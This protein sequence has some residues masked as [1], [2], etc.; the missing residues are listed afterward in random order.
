ME[1]MVRC[2]IRTQTMH[3]NT[4]SVCVWDR[5]SL[6]LGKCLRDV[7]IIVLH[8]NMLEMLL[9][10]VACNVLTTYHTKHNRMNA[11]GNEKR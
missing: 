6:S 4:L 11:L 3:N 8:W 5:V 1:C 9:D 10:A 7:F 2:K